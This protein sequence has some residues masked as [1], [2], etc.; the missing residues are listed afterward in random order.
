MTGYS[1]TSAEGD[2]NTTAS[3]LAAAFNLRPFDVT[4]A[5]EYAEYLR[6]NERYR[7]ALSVI[8]SLPEELRNDP[9]MRA[10][11]GDLY[12]D[13]KWH[14][15][16]LNAYGARRDLPKPAR[17]A[18]QDSWWLTGG[19]M[20]RVRKRMMDLENSTFGAPG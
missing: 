6:R 18:R 17:S 16:A 11:F 5:R 12:H 13:M 15:H 8:S 2:N 7:E 20:A 14:A 19:P 10:A 1:M 9:S 4:A 3:Q